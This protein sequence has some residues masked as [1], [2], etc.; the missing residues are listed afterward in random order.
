MLALFLD[1]DGVLNRH[2]ELDQNVM[3]GRLHPDK[4]ERLNCILEQTGARIVLSSAWRYLVHRGEMTLTGLEWLL[5][6]HGIHAKKLI[7]ITRPDT[8]MPSKW[9]GFDPWPQEDERGKQIA[10]FLETF[11]GMVGVP[12]SGYAVLDDLDLGITD[13]G[14]PFVKIDGRKGM[15]DPDADRVIQLLTIR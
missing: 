9:D 2:E 4:I 5:R 6:S 7:G 10:D 15:M 14:H 8:M 1:I 12:C 3:C 11:T 13:A